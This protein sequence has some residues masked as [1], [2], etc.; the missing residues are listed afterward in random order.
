MWPNHVITRVN[1]DKG[2]DYLRVSDFSNGYVWRVTG[3]CL[4]G[5]IKIDYK[6][7]QSP[8]VGNS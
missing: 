4:N 8:G 5:Y 6:L 7:L 1:P 2:S 3:T